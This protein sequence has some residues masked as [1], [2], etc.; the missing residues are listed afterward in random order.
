MHI[1]ADLSKLPFP[2]AY[3]LYWARD[4]DNRLQTADR[5]KNTVFTAYQAMKLTALLLLADYLEDEHTD[6]RLAPLIRGL[7]FPHWQEWS[8]LADGLARYWTAVEH[9]DRARFPALAADEDQ[10][11]QHRTQGGRQVGFLHE[12]LLNFFD[13]GIHVNRIIA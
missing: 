10:D 11:I 3:P 7:R 8:H 12:H 6:P 5:W 2:V 1:P 9:R 4:P 13:R